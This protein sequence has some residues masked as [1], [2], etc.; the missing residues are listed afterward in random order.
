MGAFV[1]QAN[2]LTLFLYFAS[3]GLVVSYF[4]WKLRHRGY[5]LSPFMITLLI[6]MFAVYIAGPAQYTDAAWRAL[7]TA[8]AASFL[9]QLNL[10]LTFTFAGIIVMVTSLW[11]TEG[12]R[13]RSSTTSD[14]RSIETHS[15]LRI[16]AVAIV[17]CIF[18][19]AFLLMLGYFRVLPVFDGRDSFAAEGFI[20]SAYKACVAGI[21]FTTMILITWGFL[22]RSRRYAALAIVG[23]ACSFLTGNRAGL[24]AIASLVIA[25]WIYGRGLGRVRSRTRISLVLLLGLAAAGLFLSSLRGELGFNLASALEDALYGNTFSDIRDG[26]FVLWGWQT[27]FDKEPL[28]GMTYLAASLSFLPS[29]VSD[30]RQEWSWGFFSTS[31]LFGWSDHFG[32]RGGWFLESYINFGLTGVVAV[33][34]IVGLI[35]GHVERGFRAGVVLSASPFYWQRYTKSQLWMAVLATATVS[36]GATGLL[37]SLIAYIAITAVSLF[38]RRQR[39]GEHTHQYD[40]G[41]AEGDAID[42]SLR[43]PHGTGERA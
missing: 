3:A 16:E 6:F 4:A 38:S 34:L 24:I 39:R 2:T 28:G 32:L 29:S 41:F 26:A 42:S 7:G 12:W 1:T 20:G 27:R 30:F 15:Q 40:S 22:V 35:L 37:S 18:I 36:N 33:A 19:G 25:L 14:R 10:I 23:S 21:Q 17:A 8:G 13:D 11:M 5:L 31:T 9:E 43:H